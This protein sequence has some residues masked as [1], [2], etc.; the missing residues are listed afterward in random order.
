MLKEQKTDIQVVTEKVPSLDI[1]K[2]T[3]RTSRASVDAYNEKLRKQKQ[4]EKEAMKKK[5]PISKVLQ[6]MRPEWPLMGSECRCCH[7]RCRV[8]LLCLYLCPDDQYPCR[9][10]RKP[11]RARPSRGYKPL[12]VVFVMLGIAL[13]AASRP[14]HLV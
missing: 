1:V 6:D 8:S 2:T 12:R 14:S 5:A 4:E 10:D 13:S 11:D 7:C 9:D 3:S